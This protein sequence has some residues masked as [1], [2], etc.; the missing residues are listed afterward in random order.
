MRASSIVAPLLLVAGPLQAQMV[1]TNDTLDTPRREVLEALVVVRDSL[2]P[3]EAAAAQLQRGSATAS[4]ELL[5]SRGRILLKACR[6]SLE[7]LP[8]ARAEVARGEWPQEIQVQRQREL[9]HEFSRLEHALAKC[10]TTWTRLATPEQAHDIPTVGL[11]HA[12]EITADIHRY[13]NSVGSF[14]KPLGIRLEPIG[15][16]PGVLP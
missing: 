10:D 9:M 7:T 12:Q 2:R 16:G 1:V 6:T 13:Q 8:A 11:A 5:F 4:S 14:L 15:A 3:I